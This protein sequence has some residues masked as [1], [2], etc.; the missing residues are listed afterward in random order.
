M[1]GRSPT[2]AGLDRTATE[3]AAARTSSS[4]GRLPVP[5]GAG[6]PPVPPRPD[7]AL[8]VTRPVTGC[9][10]RASLTGQVA[11]GQSRLCSPRSHL[12]RRCSAWLARLRGSRFSSRWPS[13]GRN[14]SM[15]MTSISVPW[16]A[17]RP[18]AISSLTERPGSSAS[19]QRRASADAAARRS[20]GSRSTSR[21]WRGSAS[22]CRTG[23]RPRRAAGCSRH[24]N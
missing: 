1:R 5:A 2:C 15:W 6:F 16:S 9:C 8:P 13:G 24:R 19:E 4:A 17:T 12:R 20:G 7:P 21:Q 3:R 22:G 18:A 23:R 14:H 11:A 10:R